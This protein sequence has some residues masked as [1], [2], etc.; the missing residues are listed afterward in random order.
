MNPCGL[1]AN[2]YFNDV[3]ELPGYDMT[4][5][6]IA[7]ETDV[8][9]RYSQPEGFCYVETSDT[10]DANCV[11]LLSADSSCP[12]SLSS[13]TGTVALDTT[14]SSDTNYCYYYPAVFPKSRASYAGGRGVEGGFKYTVFVKELDQRLRG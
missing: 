12:S 10:T 5:T 11:S 1:I 2:S 14:T 6:G 9:Y 13:T 3:F 4:E 8:E 7:W